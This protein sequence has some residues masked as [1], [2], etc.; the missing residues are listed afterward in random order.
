MH[1]ANGNCRAR[2]LPTDSFRV[3]Q[4]RRA[5]RTVNAKEVNFM[6][7]IEYVAAGLCSLWMALAVA[8][9]SAAEAARTFEVGAMHVERH[10]DHGAAV[11]LVPGLASG[12][13]VWS[14]V[15]DALKVD[16]RVYAVTLAGF[17]GRPF[18]GARSLL[19][20]A[21]DSLRELIVSEHIDRPVVVGHGIGGLLA[22]MFAADH[23]D[24]VSGVMAVDG[25]P[26]L[27]GT[28]H[29]P[30][31]ERSSLG[32]D[33]REQLN[34]PRAR[35]EAQQL[36]Y[37]LA[38]GV[39]D[40]DDARSLAT[41]TARSDPAATAA[42]AAEAM[43]LDLR[44]RLHDIRVPVLEISP[45][46]A[47]DFAAMGMSEAGKTAYYRSLLQGLEG[48]KVV[49]IPQARHF[50]MIDQPRAFLQALRS[51]LLE[52]EKAPAAQAR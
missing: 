39:V 22:L 28:E 15:V 26:V 2:K 19:H 30:A 7:G 48:V 8:T 17:D 35:F 34:V 33:L 37:M 9:A 52:V 41:R 6:R 50:V 24:L 40:V 12:S 51:F 1:C 16:H 23:S 32:Q 14:G 13:W 5:A 45:W 11:I 36:Q 3:L 38:M 43:A 4:W 47:S 21:A 20:S 31:S 25:L 44:P 10:G 46:L 49:A 18:I 42:Y 29:V 27:P